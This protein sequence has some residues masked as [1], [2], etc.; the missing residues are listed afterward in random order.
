MKSENLFFTILMIPF[1]AFTQNYSIEY[2]HIVDFGTNST[3]AIYILESN[4]QKSTYYQ[5]KSDFIE[6]EGNDVIQAN[7]G[8]IPFVQ[9][10]FSNKEIIYN[11]PIINKI[12]FI[13]DSLPIQKWKI[14]DKTKEIQSLK[15][16]MA[17]TFFRGREYIA[18]YTES[19]PIIGGPWK[20][21]GLPGLILEIQS[22][23]GVLKIQASK[24]QKNINSKIQEFQFKKEDLISWNEYSGNYKKVIDRIRKSMKA[25]NDPDVEYNININLVEVI[26]F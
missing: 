20:F 11:Q 4:S 8:V 5:L 13:K 9:K 15:C 6:K 22:S 25:D 18:W 10:N 14:G 21:D 19:I 23:D 24:I 12:Y 3:E 7:Q 16:K 17:T 1:I 2:N 26:D